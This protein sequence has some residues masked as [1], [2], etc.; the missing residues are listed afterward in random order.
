MEHPIFELQRRQFDRTSWK[1]QISKAVKLGAV[2]ALE[3]DKRY[4]NT[5]SVVDDM[6]EDPRHSQE[7]TENRSTLPFR[8][9]EAAVHWATGVFSQVAKYKEFPH[10]EGS[11][12]GFIY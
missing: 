10:P 3:R 5:Q 7:R 12:F 8:V 11:V 1:T 6:I 9:L 2:A 4:S